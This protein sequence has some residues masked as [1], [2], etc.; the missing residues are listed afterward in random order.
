MSRSSPLADVSRETRADLERLAD[1]V[2]KWTRRIN[3][4]SRSTIDDLW[5]RHIMDSLQLA[6]VMPTGAASWLDLG[7]GGGFPGLV[8]GIV[9]KR[10][11]ADLLLTLVESDVRKAV[12]LRT[13]IR[14]IG[15]RATVLNK[16]IE[17]LPPQSADILSARALA[18]LPTLLGYADRHLRPDG[19]ALFP[20]GATW[21]KEVAAARKEWSFTC[22]ATRSR[23]DTKSV[24]LTIG[25]VVHA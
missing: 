5:D 16:R 9:A 22:E 24:I 19:T 7:S 2:T 14:E 12:F 11:N 10:Q 20:K 21:K 23:T 17:A 25:D 13:A 8:I 3:L 6:V 4:I 15:I 1:L 18:D